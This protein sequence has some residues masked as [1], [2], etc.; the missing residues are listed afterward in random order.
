MW[1]NIVQVLLILIMAQQVYMFYFD[2]AVV[3]IS[4]ITVEGTANKNLLYEFAGR[5]ATM[6]VV[7]LIV[8]LTQNPR[9]LL[10]VLLMNIFRE[11]QETIIDPL[12]PL[13]NAPI[14][15]TADL[16]AHLVIIAIEVLAF[17]AVYR[18]VRS[19]DKAAV[20]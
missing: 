9:Y 4:G 3:A 20:E 5:T 11:G 8:L 19:M 12:Y 10:V 1:V 17:I 2:H 16:I 7:S 18:V 6:A 13:A 15:P 14:S